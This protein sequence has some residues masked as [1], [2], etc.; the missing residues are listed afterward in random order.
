MIIFRKLTLAIAVILS[1]LNTSCSSDNNLDNSSNEQMSVNTE[2][3]SRNSE[4]WRTMELSN[5]EIKQ[6]ASD[7]NKYLTKIFDETYDFNSNKTENEQFTEIKIDLIREF[8]TASEEQAY[9]EF[10]DNV[11]NINLEDLLENDFEKDY[12]QNIKSVLYSSSNHQELSNNLDI[13]ITII[14]NDERDFFKT[15]LKLYAETIKE[16]AFY[17]WPT[18]IGGSG[19]GYEVMQKRGKAITRTAMNRA[20]ETDAKALSGGMIGIA[21]YGTWGVLF[22]PVGFALTGASFI[23]VVVGSAFASAVF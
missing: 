6:M 20:A 10:F 18:E 19:I 17:W 9:N 15:P 2:N 11:R 1:L 23:G 14:D 16:S 4:L 5:A 3:F 12:V 21:A 13:I 22:G 7:H 8:S